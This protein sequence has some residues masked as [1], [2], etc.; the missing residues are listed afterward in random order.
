MPAARLDDA[1][2]LEPGE[3]GRVL[4]QRL[5]DRQLERRA[6]RGAAV[7]AALERE[8]RDAVLDRRA[9]STLPP[10]DSM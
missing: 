4:V 3:V 9:S 8:P 2:D 6:R 1:L 7:A 5:L 10:C